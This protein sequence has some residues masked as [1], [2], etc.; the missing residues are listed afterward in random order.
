MMH[1]TMNIK[2]Y[3]YISFVQFKAFII[4]EATTGYLKQ[5]VGIF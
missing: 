1:G 4:S 2:K 5:F 3:I